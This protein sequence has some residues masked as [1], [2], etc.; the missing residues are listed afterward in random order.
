[1]E[2]AKNREDCCRITE[3]QI[4]GVCETVSAQK[5]SSIYADYM[6]IAIPF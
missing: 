1:M 2:L 4:F 6:G 3:L 5:W